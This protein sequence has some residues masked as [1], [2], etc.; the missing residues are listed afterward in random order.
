MGKRKRSTFFL[1]VAGLCLITGLSSQSSSIHQEAFRPQKP[2]QYEARVTV[3]LIQIIVLDKQ[4]KPVTDLKKEGFVLTDNGQKKEITDFEKH[5]LTGPAIK[6][7]PQPSAERIVQ[8]TLSPAAQVTVMT[9][10]FFLF[11]DFAFN[12]QK[13]INKSK[14]AALHFIDTELIPDDEV[15]LLSY[16]ILKGLSIHEYLTTN[17]R[18]VREAAEA[19]NAKAIAGRAEDIEEECWR[20]AEE[21]GS[22]VYQKSFSQLDAERQESKNQAQNFILKITALAKALRYVPGQK[23]L[24]LFST[25]VPSSLLCGNQMTRQETSR[26]VDRQIQYKYDAGDNVLLTQNEKM[27]KELAAGLWIFLEM[28][29]PSDIYSSGPM[30]VPMPNFHPAVSFEGQL[31]LRFGSETI[32]L[33]QYGPAHT[34]GDVVICFPARGVAFIGDLVFVHHDL[35][36]QRHKGGYSFGL[37]TTLSIF[38]KTQPEIRTFIPSH[39]DPIDRDE[40]GAIVRSIE[41]IQVK[42][43]AMVDEGKTLEDVKKAFQISEAPKGAGNWVWPRL[44]ATVYQELTERRMPEKIPTVERRDR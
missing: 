17:H 40:L 43:L 41:E 28:N 2:L 23:H 22:G 44:A 38:L 3:K 42:V 21:S 27:L 30:S 20:R 24:V 19:L 25:G 7:E 34:S 31:N 8:T 32:G 35:L 18:K 33:F 14:E 36:I 12:N 6:T 26:I 5:I 39:A 10:K 13:G 4:G 29:A 15:G 9:R 16:S 37:V 1:P 11:F